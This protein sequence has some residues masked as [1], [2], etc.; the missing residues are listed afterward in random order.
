MGL[1]TMQEELP[2]PTL[3]LP[4]D[5]KTAGGP[6]TTVTQS[7]YPRAHGKWTW[8]CR[9]IVT[10]TLQGRDSSGDFLC[11]HIRHIIAST[12]HPMPFTQQDSQQARRRLLYELQWQHIADMTPPVPT[13]RI[14]RSRPALYVDDDITE[15]E[16]MPD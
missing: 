1:A 13:D 4:A 5:A 15:P 2:V 14:Q 11:A 8:N 16:P 12:A 3:W 9:C 10:P 6:A 7:G